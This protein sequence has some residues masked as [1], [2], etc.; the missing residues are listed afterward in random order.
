MTVAKDFLL[1]E[2]VYIASLLNHNE[3]TYEQINWII[4]NRVNS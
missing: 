1:P 3:G 2:I 4:R